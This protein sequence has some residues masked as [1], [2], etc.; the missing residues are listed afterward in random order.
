MQF[1]P[2]ACLNLRVADFGQ[3][4]W[5]GTGPFHSRQTSMV[6]FDFRIGPFC[7]DP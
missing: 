5:P 1:V 3:Y 4:L 7:T 6:A 2:V